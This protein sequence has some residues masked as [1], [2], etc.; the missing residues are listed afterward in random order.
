MVVWSLGPEVD[1]LLLQRGVVWGSIPFCELQ[2]GVTYILK[3]LNPKPQ[4]FFYT[5]PSV[6]SW[7]YNFAVYIS[8]K[9]LEPPTLVGNKFNL[10]AQSRVVPRLI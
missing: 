7:G 8:V 10:F 5:I 9:Q 2:K 1:I 6:C 3:M 4:N